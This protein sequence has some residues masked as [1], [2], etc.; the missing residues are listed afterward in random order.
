MLNKI[1]SGDDRVSYWNDEKDGANSKFKVG[2]KVRIRKD[3]K[4]GRYY[5]EDGKKFDYANDRMAR[6]AGEVVTI[7]SMFSENSYLIEEFDWSWVDGMFEGLASEVEKVKEKPKA[8]VVDFK[9]G[10][11][12]WQLSLNIQKVIHS[13]PA[14]ILFYNYSNDPEGTVR[15]MVA[16]CLPT[17]TYDREKGIQVAVFKAMRK[18]IN[19]QLEKM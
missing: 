11:W 12:K 6:L 9:G 17:D 13:E 18:L 16:R 4:E 15:K 1:E 19:K 10:Q 7:K 3:L 2:D 5:S 14:T 8:E